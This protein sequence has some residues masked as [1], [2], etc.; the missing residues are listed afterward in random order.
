MK[1][2]LNVI[3]MGINISPVQKEIK[4]MWQLVV[5]NFILKF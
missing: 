3:K 2:E 4:F 5:E 1:F